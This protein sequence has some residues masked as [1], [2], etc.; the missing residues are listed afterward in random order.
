[1]TGKIGLE[2]QNK[3]LVTLS[4]VNA[5]EEADAKAYGITAMMRAFAGAD[6]KVLQAL[7]SVGMDPGQLLALA[8]RDIA[9]NA[10][11]IGELNMSPEL[12]RELMRPKGKT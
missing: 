9:D 6:A 2:T 7:A 10:A 4:S 5:R 8:F 11:K 1:M 12:L 3:E